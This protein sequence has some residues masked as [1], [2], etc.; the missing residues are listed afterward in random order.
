[1]IQAQ[2]KNRNQL[3]SFDLPALHCHP[4]TRNVVDQD[5]GGFQENNRRK[6]FSNTRASSPLTNKKQKG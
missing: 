3:E 4:P 1:M 6:P 5:C 2:N